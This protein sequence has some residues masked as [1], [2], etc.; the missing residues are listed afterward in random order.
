[1][2]K[3]SGVT[4][5]ISRK[6]RI[7]PINL[8]VPA[9][10]TLAILGPSGAGKSTLL[11]MIAGLVQIDDGTID[12]AGALWQDGRRSKLATE[13]RN[14]GLVF[15]DGALFPHL[16]VWHN[17]LFGLHHLAEPEKTNQATIWT[18][19][20][21]ITSLKYRATGD[22]SGGERQ[23]VALARTLARD[24]KLLLLDE[25]F[26]SVDRAA[27]AD[28]IRDL[29]PLLSTVTTILVTH[30]ARDALELATHIAFMRDGAVTAFGTT[31]DMMRSPGSSWAEH[32][33]KSGTG[34][35]PVGVTHAI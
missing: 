33:L 1:M 8:A 28:L 20:L 31:S 13:Y 27:R 35:L 18:E 5:K 24:P 25:P 15:Q 26:S 23:R 21:N 12:F 6:Y 19:R 10:S 11:K 14:L 17:I 29:K 3:L 2:L 9:A 34:D 16:N 22:L 30:D 7:G 32:F 4:K